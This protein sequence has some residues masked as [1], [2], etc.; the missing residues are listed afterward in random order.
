MPISLFSVQEPTGVVLPVLS[1]SNQTIDGP[2]D[3]DITL[4]GTV[5]QRLD[6]EKKQDNVFLY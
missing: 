1:V 3:L 6:S 4:M 5:H 2:E